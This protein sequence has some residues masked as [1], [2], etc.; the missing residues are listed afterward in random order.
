MKYPI[1]LGFALMILL[2]PSVMAVPVSTCLNDTH[3]YVEESTYLDE[4]GSVTSIKINQTIDCLNGCDDDTG[5]CIDENIETSWLIPIIYVIIGGL[6]LF[7][8]LFIKEHSEL[9]YFLLAIAFLCFVIS[10]GSLVVISDMVASDTLGGI[11]STSYIV[12]IFIFLIIF[13]YLIL[14]ILYNLGII[15]IKIIEKKREKYEE[16]M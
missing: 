15:N 14:K 3:M 9:Q 1:L 8:A 10:S 5:R 2:V 13:I 6:L 11:A 7:M 4:D 12:F 16:R